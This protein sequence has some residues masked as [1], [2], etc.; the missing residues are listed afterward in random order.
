MSLLCGDYGNRPLLLPPSSPRS[1][2]GRPNC[3]VVLALQAP[4]GIAEALI[5]WCCWLPQ[6]PGDIAEALLAWWCW[7]SSSC[8]PQP[9]SKPCEG[10]NCVVVL[11]SSSCLPEAPS[12][13][14]AG[15]TFVEVLASLLHPASG[16]LEAS[17]STTTGRPHTSKPPS[18][19]VLLL[20]RHQRLCMIL[21]MRATCW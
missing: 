13:P 20:L 1:L 18:H 8:L 5:A 2:R 9:P 21:G 6:A 3:V 19:Y 10:S 12:R 7:P 14:C 17:S 11:P 4:V 16:S 15:S